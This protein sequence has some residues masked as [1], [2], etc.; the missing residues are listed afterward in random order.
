M[1]L[2][3]IIACVAFVAAEAA[4]VSLTTIWFAI[5][6]AAALLAA[7][8]GA[9]AWVQ[10][11]LFIAVSAVIL[12]L[13]RPVAKRYIAVRRMPTNADRV[14]GKVCAVTEDIDNV[15]GTGA[16]AVDGKVWTARTADGSRLGKGA[17][18]RPIAIQGVKLIVESAEKRAEETAGV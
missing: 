9:E 1:I 10:C 4:T 12:A 11:V 2:F 15:A 5:G 17:F 6:S 13:L 16:V 8:L 18:V 3:W 14:L 7:S